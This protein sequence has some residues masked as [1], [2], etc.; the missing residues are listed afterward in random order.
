MTTRVITLWRVHVQVTSLT[1]SVSTMRF[2][3]EVVFILKAIKF[4]SE[5]SY[6]KQNLMLVVISYE[7][8]ETSRTRFIHFIRNDSLFATLFMRNSVI[9]YASLKKLEAVFLD[10]LFHWESRGA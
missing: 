2:P 3:I 4:H 1:T 7:M 8:Y 10:N 9:S 5:V 6:D